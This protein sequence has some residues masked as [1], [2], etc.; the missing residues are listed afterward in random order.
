MSSSY[1]VAV[2]LGLMLVAFLVTG[3]IY[4]YVLRFAIRHNYVD[5]PDSRKL[6][7]EPVPV[8]GGVTV[9]I[10]V[11]VALAAG[12]LLLHKSALLTVL[13]LLT[14]AFLVGF[15]DDVKS[16]SPA[17]RFIVEIALVWTIIYVFNIKIGNLYGFLGIY[18]LP[19]SVSL[20]LSIVAGVGI[21]NAI[22][23]IDGVDGY[24][25]T[26]CIMACAAFAIFYYN[27]GSIVALTISLIAIGSLIPF[28]FHNVFGIKSKMFMGDAGSLMLG[29]L[30]TIFTF[31]AFSTNLPLIRV[32]ESGLSVVALTLAVLAVPVFDTLRVMAMRIRLGKSPFHADKTHLHHIFIEMNFSHLATSGIIVLGNLLI[33]LALLLAWHLGASVNFQVFLVMGLALAFTW[34]FYLFVRLEERKNGGKGSD[35]FNSMKRSGRSTN[36]SNT[37]FWLAIQRFV[38]RAS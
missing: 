25:S 20:P 8:M 19:E 16:I 13:P 26:F 3:C 24:C 28:F 17:S 27:T 4:P 38:D 15:W 10:G 31:T 21:I 7:R 23:L 9:Y 36:I 30:L 22:N 11:V 14:V 37:K 12:F 6:Q 5:K 32:Y 29:T 1:S 18:H 35:L 34:A 33:V 2:S